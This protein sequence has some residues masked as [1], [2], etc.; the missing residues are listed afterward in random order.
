MSQNAKSAPPVPVLELTRAEFAVI[1]KVE[2]QL[3]VEMHKEA[4]VE[5]VAC[6]GDSGR[7]FVC[8]P[9][10]KEVYEVK[11]IERRPLPA[12]NSEQ[13]LEIVGNAVEAIHKRRAHK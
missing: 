3:D 1:P 5:R 10:R 4:G 8:Y 13:S 9:E 11:F 7:W 12:I 6:Q 2:N